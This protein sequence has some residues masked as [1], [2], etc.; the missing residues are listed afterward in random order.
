MSK[1]KM[2]AEA[3]PAPAGGPPTARPKSRKLAA[4]AP[5]L[6]K[7][8]LDGTSGQDRKHYTDNQDRENYT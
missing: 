4:V 5:H 3:A 8:D 1:T 2:N 6:V 7:I